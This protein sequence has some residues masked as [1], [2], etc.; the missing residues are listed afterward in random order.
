MRQNAYLLTKIGADI[1]END[2][3]FAEILPKL[4][5][6]LR[7]TLTPINVHHL[8]TGCRSRDGAGRSRERANFT[9]LVREAVSK[10]NFA[11]KYVFESSRRDLHNALL[12][13][14]LKSRTDPTGRHDLRKSRGQGHDREARAGLRAE[15]P[16][17]PGR[18]PHRLHGAEG[19]PARRR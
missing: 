16:G 11:R 1:V 15:A 7:L 14:S 10:P 13:T 17:A 9:G 18:V 8:G 4:A 6:T 2:Q 12:C 3:H 19:L 5:T